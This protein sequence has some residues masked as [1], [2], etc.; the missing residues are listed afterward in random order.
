MKRAVALL[1]LATSR[2]AV[3]DESPTAADVAH[4]PLPGEESGRLDADSGDSLWRDVGQALLLPPRV[5]MELV[6]APVRATIWTLDRYK[7]PERYIQLFFDDSETYGLYPTLVL[8]SS[9]GL[10]YGG[11]FVH[12]NL[13]G[14]HEKVSL[15]A[16]TGGEYRA[17][18][19]ATVSTGERLGTSASFAATGEIERRPKDAFYGIGNS[20]E[21]VETHH[22]Q[23]LLRARGQLDVRAIHALFV[24][25]SGALTDL[26]YAPSSTAPSIETVFD[27][28]TLTGWTGA[29]NVYGELE[30]RW[31]SRRFPTKLDAQH[32]VYD[33]GSLVAAYGGR[34]HQL[35]AGN[36][37]WRYGADLQRFWRLGVGPRA[38][39]TRLHVEAVTGNIADVA[40]TEL[41]QLGGKSSLRGYPRDRFRDRAAILTSAE[42]HWDLGR[43]LMASVF[44]DVGRVYP[45]FRE[46]DHRGVRVGYGTSISLHSDRR[47]LGNISVAS[48][49]DGGVFVDFSFDPSFDLEPRVERR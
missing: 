28:M 35:R 13:F 16:A 44:V 18:A 41:P 32:A 20:V 10:T 26:T 27:T 3:A 15:R 23:E 22:R 5:A 6:M 21:S 37:Y 36:D 39:A 24:G 19:I 29:R 47:Y 9:Y 7:V 14:A 1:V 30:L 42:Y 34:V 2:L 12:R 46:L 48:S 25:V 40:F 31:D 49:I 4:A 43:L 11:R 8:D 38:L 45:A 33:S 17:Q